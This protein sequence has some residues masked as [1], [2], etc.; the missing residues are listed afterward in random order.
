LRNTP[1]MTMKHS[2]LEADKAAFRRR[3]SNRTCALQRT[4]V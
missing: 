2:R 4:V 3:G 1:T